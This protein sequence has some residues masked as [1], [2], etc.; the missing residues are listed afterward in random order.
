MAR[1][2]SIFH[3]IWKYRLHYLIV[4]PALLMITFFKLFPLFSDIYIALSDYQIF[5]G[6]WSSEFVGLDHVRALFSDTTFLQAFSNTLIIKLS[7]TLGSGIV[8]FI[9]AMAISSIQSGRVRNLFSTLFL[10]PYFIP[11]AVA[12]YV[13][14]NLFLPGSS[15]LLSESPW[16][17]DQGL[18]R[19]LLISISIVKSCGIPIIMALAAISHRQKQ[20]ENG[21]LGLSEQWIQTR[22]WPAIRAIGAFMVLQLSTL[23]STDFELSNNLFSPSIF[24]VGDT[25]NTFQFRIGFMN[26]NYSLASASWLIQCVV[27][28]VFTIV[29]YLIIRKL[30]LRDLFFPVPINDANP[31]EHKIELP[32]SSFMGSVPGICLTLLFSLLVLIPL[33]VLFVSPFTHLSDSTVGLAQ[34][35]SVKNFIVY[36]V[37]YVFVTVV[38]L[39]I[40]LT[41]AYPLTVR[42]LPGRNLYKGF[43]LLVLVMGNGLLSEYMLVNNLGMTDTTFSQIVF[44][45]YTIVSVFVLKGIFNSKYAAAKELATEERRGELLIFFTLFIPKLWKPLLA[46]GVLQ[47]ISLWGSY[48][49]SMLYIN[50]KELHSP[51]M[52]FMN[53]SS[54]GFTLFPAGS[55]D[56]II[57]LYAAV[58]TL[59]SIVLFLVFRKFI[60]SEVLLSQVRKL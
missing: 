54:G 9:L 51:I 38:S 2:T 48:Y 52:Q 31:T 42:D 59:P 33:F 30:F 13:A 11:S 14:L 10:I 43:L 26:A 27:Q 3:R 17:Q 35:I 40:T 24:H 15:N 4:L 25:L 28:L 60:T 57:M 6:V 7:Y 22:A 8:A 58:V 46:L 44:G 41:L 19:L 45:F 49:S 53:I 56:P 32:T 23:L 36:F 47:F 50:N 16:L 12:A 39:G 20:M 29:A 34:V 55:R 18:F 1:P 5:R 21:G 37:V